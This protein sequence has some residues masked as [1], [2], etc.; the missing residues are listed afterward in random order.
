MASSET[1]ELK[2]CNRINKVEQFVLPLSFYLHVVE[3]K[4]QGPFLQFTH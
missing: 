3:A 2:E 4:A 1:M